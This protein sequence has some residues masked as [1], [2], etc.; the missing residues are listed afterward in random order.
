[1]FRKLGLMLFAVM[2]VMSLVPAGADAGNGNG[3][4]N[5]RDDNSTVVPGQQGRDGVVTGR[6][7]QESG[8]C[9]YL[10]IYRGD[11]GPDPFLDNGWIMNNIT[12]PTENGPATYHYLM[13]HE[14]DPR[15]TG[16]GS[17]TLWGGTW[18]YHVLTIGG[19]DHSEGHGNILRPYNHVG[20]NE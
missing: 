7:T 14:T 13:V 12:C 6:Y 17:F 10:V 1:M 9:S 19:L 16:D 3:R 15:F 8:G 20:N 5:N 4:G 2:M 18:E 11:F